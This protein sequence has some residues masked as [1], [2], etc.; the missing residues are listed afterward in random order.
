MVKYHIPLRM[1]EKLWHYFFNKR[2][3]IRGQCLQNSDT[4]VCKGNNSL[5]NYL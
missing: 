4:Q 5:K 3:K 1:K 2:N